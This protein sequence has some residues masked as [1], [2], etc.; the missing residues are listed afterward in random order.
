MGLGLNCCCEAK[1]SLNCCGTSITLRSNKMN[2]LLCGAN[3]SWPLPIAGLAMAQRFND[4]EKKENKL[5]SG[6]LYELSKVSICIFDL[7]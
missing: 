6:S 3:H 2:C 7:E 1:F 4:H 5:L